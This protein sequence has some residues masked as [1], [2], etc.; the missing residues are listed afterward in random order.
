MSDNTQ[1][2]PGSL[3]DTIRDI[4]RGAGSKTQV[5]QLDLGG[6]NTN[7]ENLITAGQK[8]KTNSI[9]IVGSS[10]EDLAGKL[11]LIYAELKL[12]TRFLQI[13]LSIEDEPD[14]FR[15]DPSYLS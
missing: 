8:P 5:V 3:G 1:L 13:G 4:D 7:P 15:K 10:E 2:N 9:P 6:P 14:D 11:D 12:I